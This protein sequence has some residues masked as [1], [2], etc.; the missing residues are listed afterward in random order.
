VATSPTSGP[1]GGGDSTGLT[2]VTKTFTDA[3]VKALPAAGL[4]GYTLVAAQGAGT[5]VLPVSGLIVLNGVAYT[6]VA[7][8]G[9]LYLCH[10]G[11]NDVNNSPAILAGDPG[12]PFLSGAG[13]QAAMIP[14]TGFQTDTAGPAGKYPAGITSDL[15]SLDNIDLILY[16]YNA[17]SGNY[18]GGDAANTLVIHLLYIVLSV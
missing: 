9:R 14:L 5:V 17:A 10:T 15:D 4:T 3:Q 7:A 16:G 12:S 18:T 8:T 2:L 13:D 1:G 6:N 11:F